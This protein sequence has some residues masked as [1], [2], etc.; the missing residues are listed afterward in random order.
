VRGC[1]AAPAVLGG[2]TRKPASGTPTFNKDVAPIFF[3]NCTNCHRAGEIAPMSLLS[4]KDAQPW[5]RAIGQQV[6]RGAMPPWHADPAH[7]QFLNDRR[8]SDAEKVTIAQWV[9]A[10]APEGD[11]ADL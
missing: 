2:Q 5:A 7:G 9:S 1:A 4:Y 6:A 11:P 3:R 10:G 8:L